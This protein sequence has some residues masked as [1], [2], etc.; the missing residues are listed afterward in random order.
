M[1]EET[2]NEGLLDADE[3]AESVVNIHD[4]TSFGAD[5][6][7]MEDREEAFANLGYTWNGKLLEGF[8][9]GRDG[10]FVRVR[11]LLCIATDLS[12]ELRELDL[13]VG[14]AQVIIWLCSHTHAEIVS[15]LTSADA[16]T[17]FYDWVEENIKR[18]QS[19]HAVTTAID[20]YNDSKLN[21]AEGVPDEDNPLRRDSSG[22]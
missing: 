6:E 22:N 7:M 11:R 4:D 13:F 1:N 14:S 5:A 10:L 12:D 8:G 9:S 3:A 16:V 19:G 20:I 21:Q 17:Q 2:K 18:D 15:V